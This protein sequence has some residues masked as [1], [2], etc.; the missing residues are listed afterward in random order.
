MEVCHGRR[1]VFIS[2][3]TTQGS[4]KRF[5]GWIFIKQY[6]VCMTVHKRTCRHVGVRKSE[7]AHGRD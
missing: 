5:S 2:L 6:S 4:M 3:T 7:V 1:D